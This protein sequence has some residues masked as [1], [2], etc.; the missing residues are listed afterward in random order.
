MKER[1]RIL[2]IYRSD[3]APRAIERKTHAQNGLSS[4]VACF[5]VDFFVV[6][7]FRGLRYVKPE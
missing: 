2:R 4:S 1:M 6:G 3:R 5:F 7:F